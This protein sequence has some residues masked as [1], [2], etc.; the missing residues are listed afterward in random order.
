MHGR[1]E[2]KSDC[3]RAE[4]KNA[5][6]GMARPM[7]GDSGFAEN[8]KIRRKIAEAKPP[9]AYAGGKMGRRHDRGPRS[10]RRHFCRDNRFDVDVGP[11]F[12]RPL[13]KARRTPWTMT[14]MSSQSRHSRAGHK[15][16]HNR[17]DQTR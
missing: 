6:G 2:E 11:L 7:K 9:P 10:S 12:L 4:V 13:P 1:L 3:H 14:C 17:N 16:W 15:L 5:A 8:P